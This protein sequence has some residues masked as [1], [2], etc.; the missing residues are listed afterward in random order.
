M[1]AIIRKPEMNSMNNLFDTFFRDEPLSWSQQLNN[2]NRNPLVNIS[3]AENR[4]TLE[5]LVPG[6]EKDQI[7]IEIDKGLL[8]LS[9][10]AEKVE[11]GK[12]Q[13]KHHRKEFTKQ[14]FKRSFQFKETQIDEENIKAQFSNGI[15]LLELP[16]KVKEEINTKRSIEII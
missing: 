4:F 5:L 16:K 8:T 10:E 14:S 2:V 6:F 15:L 3:E 13:L 11:N 12:P 9:A 7:K 1:K